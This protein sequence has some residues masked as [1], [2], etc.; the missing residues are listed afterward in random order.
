VKD[1][2]IAQTVR[3][4]KAIRDDFLKLND[5]FEML[6]SIEHRSILMGRQL[7]PVAIPLAKSLL[8]LGNKI[9]PGKMI[10]F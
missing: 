9:T 7:A 8:G 1:H 3:I 6:A 2:G 4:G 5:D 10:S